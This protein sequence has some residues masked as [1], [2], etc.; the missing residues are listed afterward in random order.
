MNEAPIRILL[1]DD[2]AALREP[3]ADY[4]VRQVFVVTHAGMAA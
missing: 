1:V 4:L 2:E 3:L